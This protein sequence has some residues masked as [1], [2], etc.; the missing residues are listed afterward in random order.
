MQFSH[1]YIKRL[2]SP[3]DFF[4]FD[5]TPLTCAA[6]PPLFCNENSAGNPPL[7]PACK[8][9]EVV[10][11]GSKSNAAVTSSARPTRHTGEWAAV[12]RSSRT[13]RITKAGGCSFSQHRALGHDS[14]ENRLQLLGQAKEKATPC[15]ATCRTFEYQDQ[16][17]Q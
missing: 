7:S 1:D 9:P 6:H 8:Q 11:F 16:I 2:A 10:D 3:Y 4:A 17:S 14:G 5:H 15:A 13:R 12:C